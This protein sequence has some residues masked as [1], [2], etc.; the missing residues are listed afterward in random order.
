MRFF[1]LFILAMAVTIAGAYYQYNVIL[2]TPLNPSIE[3]TISIEVLPKMTPNQVFQILENENVIK[4]RKLISLVAKVERLG[5][6]IK[7]GEYDIS[8]QMTTAQ[9]F[10]ILQTGK[11]KGRMITIPEGYNIFEIA[12]IFEREN[13]M[14][15]KE[16][17]AYVT[18]PSIVEALLSEQRS[19][20]EGYLFPDSYQV[21]KATKGSDLISKM[22]KTFLERYQEFEAQQKALG[23]SRHQVITLASIIEKETGAPWE[24]PLIARVFHNRLKKRMKLQTDPTVL[25]AKALDTGEYEIKISRSDLSRPHPY[26]TYYIA[27]LP[28]GPIA[29][30]GIESIRSVF[31]PDPQSRAL[32]FVSRNDGTHV[33]SET[34]EQHNDAVTAYQKNPKARDGRSWRELSDKLKKPANF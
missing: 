24:R 14:S 13:L 6:L 20:L 21:T 7:A 32:Y 28:P 2:T 1:V 33:F 10:A 3:K 26:N 22:V 18:N 9:L 8:S 15:K 4:N 29:N 30:P 17:L 16:F 25:Y 23:W 31:N 11:V 27:A 19:S 5:S 12:S 34:F